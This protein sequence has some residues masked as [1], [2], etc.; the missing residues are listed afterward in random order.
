M[1]FHA[2]AGIFSTQRVQ[3]EN[4]QSTQRFSTANRLSDLRVSCFLRDLC[5]KF[6]D[7]NVSTQSAETFS[8]RN[9]QLL[10]T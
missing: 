9:I 2:K 3:S 7:E 5:V 1:I 8:K 4:T 10:I 6:H